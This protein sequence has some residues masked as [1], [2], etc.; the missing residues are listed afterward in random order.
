M[1]WALGGAGDWCLL[2]RSKRYVG[3]WASETRRCQWTCRAALAISLLSGNPLCQVLS[4]SGWDDSYVSDRDPVVGTQ[5]DKIT[6]RH[7]NWEV[8][9]PLCTWI[10]NFHIFLWLKPLLV[11]R[12]DS[13]ISKLHR[14]CSKIAPHD[15]S[16]FGLLFSAVS[17]F[18]SL[19]FFFFCSG[20]VILKH[21]TRPP[22]EVIG[23]FV[24][25]FSCRCLAQL[26]LWQ[27]GL[28][29]PNSI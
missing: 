2:V 24:Y 6:T 16:C 28:P 12:F 22:H 27:S 15:S 3:L 21:Q 1:Q 9:L 20:S 7:E 17:L 4:G 8:L 26:G 11:G 14:C 5:F 29:V 25:C 23:T 13:K 10:G 19:W 18:Y